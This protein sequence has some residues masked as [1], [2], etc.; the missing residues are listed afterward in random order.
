MLADKEANGVLGCIKQSIAS[1][2]RDDPS[3]LLS[4]NEGTHGVLYPVLGL[5][6]SRDMDILERVQHRASKVIKG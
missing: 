6:Y 2:F 4:I 1:S 5:Q 3:I